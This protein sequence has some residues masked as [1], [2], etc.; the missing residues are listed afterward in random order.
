MRI[1]RPLRSRGAQWVSRPPSPT[2]AVVVSRVPR[3]LVAALLIPARPG[4]V[5][6]VSPPRAFVTFAP[7]PPLIARRA[8]P[9]SAGRTL[10]TQ[11]PRLFMMMPGHLANGPKVVA[12]AREPVRRGLVTFVVP[13]RPFVPLT[14]VRPALVA[15]L[16]ARVVWERYTGGSAVPPPQLRPKPIGVVSGTPPARRGSALINQPVRLFMM[17]PGH[18]ANGPRV[19]AIL[20]PPRRGGAVWSVPPRARVTFSP[21]PPLIARRVPPGAAGFA[22]FSHPPL[23]RVAPKP[24]PAFIAAGLPPLRRGLIVNTQPP[25]LFMVMSGRGGAAVRLP[26]LRPLAR[27][28]SVLFSRPPR[29]TV[30]F[31]P[32]PLLLA[33][34]VLPGRAGGVSFIGPPRVFAAP[35]LRSARPPL[36]VR[37]PPVGA[38]GAVLFSRP[39]LPFVPPKPPAASVV[40]VLPPGRRGLVTQAGGALVQLRVPAATFPDENKAVHLVSGVPP[41]RRGAVLWVRPPRALVTFRPLPVQVVRRVPPG[42]AGRALFVQG[43]RLSMVMTGRG[44]APLIARRVPPGAAGAVL[45]IRRPAPNIP[46]KPPP[47]RLVTFLP[48]GAR[49]RVLTTQPPRPR[50]TPG[51]PRVLVVRR[52]PPGFGGAILRTPY[53]RQNAIT[54]LRGNPRAKVVL[55]PSPVSTVVFTEG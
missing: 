31:R 9:G 47:A 32:L 11:P 6:A 3:I 50:V 54:V 19:V 44:G 22:L 7:K 39:R 5:R 53:A 34:R 14:A 37:R 24:P 41:G 29:L 48:P 2:A 23:P 49:G 52:V 36:I 55:R 26:A 13:P 42:A 8:P 1:I 21:K 45:F 12:I 43:P 20:P 28:G 35:P 15:R 46:P 40:S 25:R 51:I 30:T 4:A 38:A 17:M 33:R 27:P 18:G 16:P 10:N